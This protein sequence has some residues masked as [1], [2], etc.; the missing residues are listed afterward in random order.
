MFESALLAGNAAVGAIKA[1]DPADVPKNFAVMTDNTPDGTGFGNGTVAGLKAAG[2]NVVTYEQFSATGTPDFSSIILKF[3]EM[4][5]D[6]MVTLIDPAGGITFVKQMKQGDWSPKF[7][8]GYKGFWPSDFANTLGADANYIGH[9][10]FWSETFPFPYAKEL[11]AAYSADFN[12]DTSNSVGLYY[13]AVQILATAIERAGTAEPGPV[14][15]QGF[16][17]SFPGSTMGVSVYGAY[18]PEA[19]GI[20]HIPFVADQWQ[21]DKKRTVIFPTEFSQGPMMTF[22]PWDQR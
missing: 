12:G 1:M 3:K 11:G 13:A 2:Y 17:G 4:N 16:N 20:A 6:G 7:I 5:V 8:F 21:P 19:P 9:D 10:G 22:V 15:V 14:R 18:Y